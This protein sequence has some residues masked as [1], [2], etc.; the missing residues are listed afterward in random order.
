VLCLTGTQEQ[1]DQLNADQAAANL[2]H[3]GVHVTHALQL[4]PVPP[5]GLPLTP[6]S[7][8]W[9]TGYAAPEQKVTSH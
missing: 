1:V 9:L 7:A 3:P 6:P 5:E 2:R 8:R 4:V